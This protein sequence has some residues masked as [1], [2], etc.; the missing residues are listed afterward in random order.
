MRDLLRETIY[1]SNYLE[2]ENAK[3]NQK[4]NKIF[5]N[6]VSF[7][8]KNFKIGYTEIKSREDRRY[9]L[10]K[11]SYPY[12]E[13]FSWGKNHQDTWLDIKII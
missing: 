2:I 6:D 11:F 12:Y 5:E 4:F 9:L 3:L 13:H 7:K 10:T 1:K 8:K